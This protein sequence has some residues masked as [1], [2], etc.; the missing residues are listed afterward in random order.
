MSIS[1]LMSISAADYAKQELAR[2]KANKEAN[3]AI[4]IQDKADGYHMEWD[5]LTN[6][7]IKVARLAK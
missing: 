7:W 1:K 4:K 2:Y 3:Q 5:R 6:Q